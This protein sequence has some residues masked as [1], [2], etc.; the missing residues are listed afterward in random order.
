[1][2]QID[3][4]G[5]RSI[6]EETAILNEG[7]RVD[8]S[9]VPGQYSTSTSYTTTHGHIVMFFLNRYQLVFNYGEMGI[10]FIKIMLLLQIFLKEKSV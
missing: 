1:M 2:L 10:H 5:Q 7:H 9:S 8:L 3:N 4:N 6:N